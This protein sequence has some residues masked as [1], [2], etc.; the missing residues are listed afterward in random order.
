[1]KA[2]NIIFMG[3]LVVAL[4]AAGCTHHWGYDRYHRGATGMES[5]SRKDGHAPGAAGMAT[6]AMDMG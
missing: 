3:L 6:G 5:I 4:F 1:M 2:R